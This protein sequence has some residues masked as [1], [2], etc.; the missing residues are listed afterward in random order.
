M[1]SIAHPVGEISRMIAATVLFCTSDI[2]RALDSASLVPDHN[3]R[4]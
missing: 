2:L 3:D 4:I 1:Q